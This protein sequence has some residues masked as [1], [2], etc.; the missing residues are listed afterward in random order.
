VLDKVE[1]KIA[2]K[3]GMHDPSG[4]LRGVNEKIVRRRFHRLNPLTDWQTDMVREIAEKVTG[5][6]IS[7][8]VSN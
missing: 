3:H 1:G 6:N 5:K 7:S 2:G 4:N 8:S